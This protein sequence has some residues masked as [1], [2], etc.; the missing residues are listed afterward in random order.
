MTPKISLVT[1]AT[2]GFASQALLLAQSACA[3]GFDGV[4]VFQTKD[5]KGTAFWRENERVLTSPRGGG[6]WLWKPHLL[7]KLVRDLPPGHCLLYSDA[8]RTPYYAFTS[9]PEYLVRKMQL[10]GQGFLLGCPAPHLGQVGGWTKRDCL[11]L[12]GAMGA[13]R[14][15]APLIMTW[16]LWTNS[17]QAIAFLEHW[18]AFCSDPRCLTDQPNTLGLPDLPGFQSH[19]FDQSVFSILAHQMNAPRVDFTADLV[20]R[21]ISLRPGS[22]LAHA[23]YKRPQNAEDLLAGRWAIPV[24]VREFL[25]LRRFRGWADV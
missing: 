7:L 13:E 2:D 15:A 24:L 19:R 3:A 12:M 4:E 8:G 5:I 25:R 6:F 23:F 9:R 10:A 17:P 20:H 1:Y 11:E 21:L 18:L 14:L 22:E 16:S